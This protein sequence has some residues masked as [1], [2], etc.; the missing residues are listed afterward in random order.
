MK[1]LIT[2]GSGFIGTY[3]VSDL[4]DLGHDVVIYDKMKSQAFPSCCIVGDVRDREH[5]TKA[6]KGVDIV[7]HLAAEHRDDVRPVSLYYDVNVQGARNLI[8][9][10]DNHRIN[11]LVF[12]SSV[13]I[14]GLNSGIPDENSPAKP[15]NEYSSTKTQAEQLFTEWAD[16]GDGRSLVI[17]RP[18]AIFGENNRGN[19]YNLLRQIESGRFIM[20]GNGNNVKSIGYVRNLSL[21]LSILTDM[22]AGIHV[23]NYADQPEFTMKAFISLAKKTLARNGKLSNI[24]LPYPVGLAAGYGFDMLAKITGKRFPVSSVRIKKFCADTKINSNRI[25]MTGFRAPFSLQEGL[26]RMIENEF[27][28]TKLSDCRAYRRYKEDVIPQ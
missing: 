9:A 22:E 8:A 11:R 27:P 24:K 15:F 26:K 4:L 2:G 14:Y 5:L 17:V 23:F 18:A 21:F 1:I 28:H 13:A 25:A 10:C 20:V 16:D 7:F 19:V 12:T 6:L 3:L